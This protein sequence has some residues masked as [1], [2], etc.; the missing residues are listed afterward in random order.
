MPLAAL[1]LDGPTEGK[2]VGQEMRNDRLLLVSVGGRP[3][4]V[5]ESNKV[6]AAVAANAL[7]LPAAHSIA[8]CVVDPLCLLRS[9][10]PP[11][12]ENDS[13]NQ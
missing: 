5:R 10:R 2:V 11:H 7:R 12:V 8:V 6:L 3:G 1:L 4:G 9:V 13:N